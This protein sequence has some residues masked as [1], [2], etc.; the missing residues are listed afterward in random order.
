MKV[1]RIKPLGY[2]SVLCAGLLG[3]SLSSAVLWAGSFSEQE[4]KAPISQQQFLEKMERRFDK[5][6]KNGDGVISRE[7]FMESAQKRFSR[8]DRDQDGSLSSTDRVQK[9]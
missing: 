6:D 9:N 5:K 7:E 3:V 8:M 2:V 4:K 1:I